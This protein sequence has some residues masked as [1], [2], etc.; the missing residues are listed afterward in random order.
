MTVW[1]SRT[2]TTALHTPRPCSDLDVLGSTYSK[3]N[4]E[5]SAP[6]GRAVEVIVEEPQYRLRRAP[7]QALPWIKFPAV[8]LRV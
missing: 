2:A 3:S 8:G 4:V 6:K 5:V 1:P 7:R